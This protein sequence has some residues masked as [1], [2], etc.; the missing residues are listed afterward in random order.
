MSSG[1]QA[2]VLCGF[3]R[4]I[5]GGLAGPQEDQTLTNAA[6]AEPGPAVSLFPWHA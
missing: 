4:G 3:A 2:E 6:D 5:A 1:F